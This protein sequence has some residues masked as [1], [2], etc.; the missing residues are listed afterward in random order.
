MLGIQNIHHRFLL[1]VAETL[2]V[3]F[4]KSLGSKEAPAPTSQEYQL[5]SGL[6][7][8][9][10]QLPQ[11]ELRGLNRILPSK[12][13]VKVGSALISMHWTPD[14]VHIFMDLV[15]EHEHELYGKPPIQWDL[16]VELLRA[17]NVLKSEARIRA[18]YRTLSR[19]PGSGFL[20]FRVSTWRRIWHQLN[21]F[22]EHVER[23]QLICAPMDENDLFYHIPVLENGYH[24]ALQV[25]QLF[26]HRETVTL[27]LSAAF[28]SQFL[29]R[30][31]PSLLQRGV[32]DQI[33]GKQ[34]HDLF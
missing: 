19:V 21:T 33:T 1:S 30:N 11:W 17:R 14:E 16:L 13:P 22:K 34:C 5:Q 32:W 12:Q 29:T 9:P 6:S 31:L 2:D 20:S 7:L 4:L 23:N 25:G 15:R 28:I 27:G 18:M 26:K 3:L 10:P 24:T 8:R